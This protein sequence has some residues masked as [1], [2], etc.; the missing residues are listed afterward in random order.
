MPWMCVSST[1]L[2]DPVVTWAEHA[3]V[4]K[5]RAAACVVGDCRKKKIALWDFG[6]T[7]NPPY[8]KCMGCPM[9]FFH[10]AAPLQNQSHVSGFFSVWLAGGS[11]SLCTALYSGQSISYPL[12]WPRGK[13]GY[14][15]VFV[16]KNVQ[17]SKKK[18][19]KKSADLFSCVWLQ[20]GDNL[21]A[22]RRNL[23]A[24]QLDWQHTAAI[25]FQPIVKTAFV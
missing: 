14:L 8:H 25:E 1:L 6:V 4:Q 12:A 11:D 9:S 21:P 2:K 23:S 22:L 10:R 18:K 20:T 16:K 17:S 24:T 13:M 5:G 19:K 15:T 3:R 7:L